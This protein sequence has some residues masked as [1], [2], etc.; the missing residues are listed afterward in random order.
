MFE[1]DRLEKDREKKDKKVMESIIYDK[2]KFEDWES[3]NLKVHYINE[4]TKDDDMIASDVTTKLDN[5]R[6]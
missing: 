6:I 3:Q 2:A 1:K 4:L 5:E